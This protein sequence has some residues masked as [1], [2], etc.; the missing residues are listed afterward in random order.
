MINKVIN[1]NRSSGSTAGEGVQM[2]KKQSISPKILMAIALVV[3]IGV[4]AVSL[5]VVRGGNGSRQL[6]EKLDLADRYMDEMD[7][8]QA[9]AC[10]LEILKIDPT[11][12]DAYVGFAVKRVACVPLKTREE[13]RYRQE[14]LQDC[15]ANEDFVGKLYLHATQI[16]ALLIRKL[17]F[18]TVIQVAESLGT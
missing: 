8:E 17:I 15:L 10:F 2:E 3:I 6:Q 18:Q 14:I 1:T 12:E 13:V 4:V 16:L 7:Y 9:V 11:H 5:V